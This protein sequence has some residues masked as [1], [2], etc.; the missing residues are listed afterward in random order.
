MRTASGTPA[1]ATLETAIFAVFNT[2]EAVT[3]AL[4]A[5]LPGRTWVR[6]IDTAAP[7][8]AAKPVQGRLRVAASSI[9]ALVQEE[10]QT[11]Q[12]PL[13]TEENAT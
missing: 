12:A 5:P 8:A 11:V 6:Q 4:P 10:D 2:G 9:V 13:P 1:Y 7:D 3:V